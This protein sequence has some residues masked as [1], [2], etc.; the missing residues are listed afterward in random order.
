MIAHSQRY[1]LMTQALAGRLLLRIAGEAKAW[2]IT[3]VVHR[4]PYRKTSFQCGNL[5]NAYPSHAQS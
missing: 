2:D 5:K 4:T 3:F 1:I